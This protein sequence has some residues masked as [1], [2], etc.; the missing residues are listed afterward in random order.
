[1]KQP[2]TGSRRLDLDAPIHRALRFR[3]MQAQ[4]PPAAFAGQLDIAR[5][6]LDDHGWAKL[7]AALATPQEVAA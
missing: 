1:M 5:A 2:A 4:L 7:N 6:A 3:A